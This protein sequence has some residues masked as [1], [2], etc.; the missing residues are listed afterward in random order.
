M[1][2]NVFWDNIIYLVKKFKPFQT[3]KIIHDFTKYYSH[4][5]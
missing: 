4:I 2:Q 3:I 1:L 5:S